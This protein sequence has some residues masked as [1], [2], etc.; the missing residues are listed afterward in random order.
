MIEFDLF[1]QHFYDGLSRKR[2]VYKRMNNEVNSL[3][4]INFLPIYLSV[5][6]DKLLIIIPFKYIQIKFVRLLFLVCF[7]C[8]SLYSLRILL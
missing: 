8:L 6:K 1:T 4:Y 3:E 5:S 7:V 2:K